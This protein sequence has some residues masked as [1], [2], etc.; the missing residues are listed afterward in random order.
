MIGHKTF[1]MMGI[2]AVGLA[3]VMSGLPPGPGR[4]QVGDLFDKVITVPGDAVWVDTGLDVNPG[5]ELVIRAFGEVSLQRGNPAAACGPDGLDML[6]IDQP[7]PKENLGSLVGKV[8]QFVASRVDEDSGGEV[9]DEIFV[10]FIIGS[11][12]TVPVPL[13]GRFYLGVNEKVTTDNGGQFAVVIS[14]RPVWSGT[15]SK[16]NLPPL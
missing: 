8:A 11:E 6:T 12:R 10:L 3:A 2:V 13:K 4:Q 14:R 5:E 7:V 16:E 9:R 1:L 15:G